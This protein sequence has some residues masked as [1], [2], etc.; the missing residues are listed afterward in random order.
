MTRTCLPRHPQ[1]PPP[2]RTHCLL[3]C[4]CRRC[5]CRP[6]ERPAELP[7]PR[8]PI[9][10]RRLP[11]LRHNRGQQLAQ[12]PVEGQDPPRHA[13][14]LTLGC[15]LDLHLQHPLPGPRPS[16][17]SWRERVS[18]LCRQR[19]LSTQSDPGAPERRELLRRYLVERWSAPLVLVGEAPGWR[20]AR[21]SGIAFTSV[22]QLGVGEVNEASATIVHRTLAELGLETDVL[23]WNSVPTHPHRPGAPHSNRRPSA[24]EI[25]AGRTF[26]GAVCEGRTVVAVGRVA[27][28]CTNA[29]FTVRHPAHGGT[30]AFAAGMHGVAAQ[31]GVVTAPPGGTTSENRHTSRGGDARAWWPQS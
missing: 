6:E 15:R 23:L 19:P 22:A 1:S 31:L 25:A 16:Q 18:R 8:H 27:A 9:G 20:G 5:P 3:L 11:A 26:L 13:P 7:P 29:A 24:T 12:P 21:L 4:V 10:C 17:R 14:P 30:R 28:E 2:W